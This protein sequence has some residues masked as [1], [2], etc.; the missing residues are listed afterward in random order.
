MSTVDSERASGRGGR[1]DAAGDA[2]PADA[3][4]AVELDGV[5]KR[6]GDTAAVDGVSLR[7]REGEF[8]T[9]VGPS[10]CGKTT[11][12][13][14]IAGFEEPTGGTPATDSPPNRTVPAVGASKP[15]ISRSVVVF[16][17]PDGPTSVKNSPSRTRR[18]TPSTASV[19]P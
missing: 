18:L 16:P 11:T 2:D 17:H 1:E 4:V 8:F 19:S 12:L 10:G 14:L 6:Y 13:R 15:A 7:V 5:T 3:P 9:L